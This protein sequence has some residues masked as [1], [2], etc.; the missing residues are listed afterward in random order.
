MP[1]ISTAMLRGTN[2]K[3]V[4]L[5]HSVQVCIG[6]LLRN[7]G[8][9]KKYD[10][11][12]VKWNIAGINHMAWATEIS[13]N[14][15]DLYPEIKREAKKLLSQIKKR[16][17]AFKVKE[18]EKKKFGEKV[19]EKSTI[20]RA[21][22]DM[23][24]LYIML[25]FGYYHT[26]SSEHCSEY[27]PYFIKKLYPELIEEFG[28]PLDEYPR[29]CIR[30]IENWKTRAKD[31]V[32]NKKLKHKRSHEYGSFIMEAMETDVPFKIGGNV[33]NN[34]LITNLPS[35]M[36]V[37]VPCLVDRNGIQGVHVGALPEQCAA[38]NRTNVNVHLLVTE[39]LL[40]GKKEYIYHAAMLDPHTRSE[41][42]IDEIRKLCDELIKAHGS[43]M[44]KF[45]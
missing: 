24:R 28:I 40:T 17:G 11:E 27:H 3:Y 8:L 22:H 12:K 42:T 18:E 2:I 15:K 37:E 38:L 32:S 13:F 36:A 21:A 44:P 25:T 10:S 23:I 14:G 43:M 45:K 5:C 30:Q 34:G 6:A 33:I 16:G 35:N 20:F 26:E 1:A 41:L 29:R 39:A 19:A 4:G 31:I 9:D 7:V